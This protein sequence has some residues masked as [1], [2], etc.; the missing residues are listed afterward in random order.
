MDTTIPG[1]NQA[2]NRTAVHLHGGL[3]PWIS[4]GG[5]FD[6]WAPNGTSGASFLNNTIL[7]P[8]AA[9]NQAE[10]YY[11]N[12]QSARL[13]WYHDH[14]WGITRINAYAGIASAYVITD[15]YEAALAAA[16]YNIPGPLDP[17]TLYL[18]FQDKIFLHGTND[19]ITQCLG[20][21]SG[22]LWYAHDYD[23]NRWGTR[24]EASAI[25]PTRRSSRSSSATRSWSTARSTPTWKW[26]RDSTGFRM[27]NA[28]NARF[29]K[30][31]LVY[32]QN[33]TLTRL[34]AP[35]PTRSSR[36]R[37]SYRSSRKADSCPRLRCSMDRGRPVSSWHRRKEAISSWTSGMSLLVRS[38][39]FTATRPDHIPRGMR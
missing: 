28:C 21:R 31:K 38:S 29:L 30:P 12:K 13:V 32:A 22:D 1:A 5:P 2:Q 36:A 24:T 37:P 26:S 17:R 7:H 33:N 23:P 15:D 19:P 10:Y 3:V 34:A 6:W 27:L 20:A 35:K 14:A 18:V 8:G 4:D 25:R 39:S 16:P 9:V 11:P